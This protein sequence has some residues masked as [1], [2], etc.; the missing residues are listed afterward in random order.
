[1]V[2][3]TK[4]FSIF[5]HGS[6]ASLQSLSDNTGKSVSLVKRRRYEMHIKGDILSEKSLV[7]FL[8]GVIQ[9]STLSA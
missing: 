6:V 4:W 2:C 1:M 8:Q 7:Q 5:S 9:R 3:G